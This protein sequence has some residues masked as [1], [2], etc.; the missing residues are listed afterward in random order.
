MMVVVFW[1]LVGLVLFA[2]VGFPLC[3]MGLGLLLRRRHHT[4]PIT[5]VVSVIVAAY[6]EAAGIA[7]KIRNTLASRYPEDRLEV[8]VVDDGSTDGTAREVERLTDPRVRLLRQ[9][10][11]GGKIAALNRGVPQGRG[12]I[13]VFTDANAELEPDA[14]ARLVEPFADPSV[15]GVCGN[16]L[17]RPGRGP[18]ARGEHVYWEYDKLLKR[19]ESLTGSIV[20]ADGSIYAIRRD[21]FEA[22]PPGVTDDFFVSTAVVRDGARL[23]FAEAAR[24]LEAPPARRVPARRSSRSPRGIS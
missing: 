7:E 21:H 2:F 20:A 19:M 24:S 1:A 6:N 13:L 5:P 23:V 22:I 4:R 8:I 14:V 16:Q 17:N 15:G 9:E 18:L 11:R 10:R 3:V 12:E